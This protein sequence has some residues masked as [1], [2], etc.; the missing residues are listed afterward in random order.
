MPDRIGLSHPEVTMRDAQ[1]IAY[2][3][4]AVLLAIALPACGGETAVHSADGGSNPKPPGGSA[5]EWRHVSSGSCSW[6]LSYVGT[7]EECPGFSGV[8]TQAQCVAVCTPPNSSDLVACTVQA[9]TTVDGG[10]A[11]VVNCNDQ[12]AGC[13]VVIPP[14]NGGRRPD[15]F[16]SLGFGAPPAGR[17]VGT[18]FAR[19]ALLEAGSVEAFR[20]LRDELVAHRAPRSLVRAASRAI[21]DERR[22]VRQ[23]AALAGRFGEQPIAH[24]PMRPRAIRSLAAMALENAVE[25]CVRETYSALEC[26]WQAE[27][28]TDPVVRGT[29]KRI[30]RDE[31]RHLALAW[32]VHAWASA[33]LSPAGRADLIAAQRGALATLR[34]ELRVDPHASL[35]ELA[36]LPRAAQSQVLVG[37]IEAKVAA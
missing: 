37:A 11:G 4:R 26:A 3:Q 12:G 28:A 21:R 24:G 19:V 25:G 22:H 1:W 13:N 10:S 36:G 15:Y 17:E 16:A 7:P 8:G 23:T 35:V 5:C 20:R 18:H 6:V 14:G 33:R 29:M 27:L 30:A 34:G 2:F 32:R 31:M 9:E